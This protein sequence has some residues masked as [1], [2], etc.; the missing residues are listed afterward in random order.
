MQQ[1]IASRRIHHRLPIFL[2]EMPDTSIVYSPG[3]VAVVPTSSV[4]DLENALAGRGPVPPQWLARLADGFIELGRKA[5]DAWEEL[6]TAEMQPACLTVYLSNA[7]NLGCSYCF[8]AERDG[9]R[10]QPKSSPSLPILGSSPASP[11]LDDQKLIPA[12]RF[13]AESCRRQG[14]PFQLVVHGGGEATLHWDL[15]QRVVQLTK[16]VAGEQG[17]A[18]TSY[19]ASHGAI[20]PQKVCWLA[21]HF[22]RIGISCDGPPDIHDAQRS[23]LSGGGTYAN[24]AETI[25]ILG[26]SGV[27]LTLRA[28]ITRRSLRRQTEIVA[29]FANELGA[30]DI[31]FE[32]MYHG[33]ESDALEPDDAVEFANHFLAAQSVAEALGGRLKLSGVRLDEIHGPYCNVLRDVIQITPDHTASACFLVTDGRAP[34]GAEMVIGAVNPRTGDFEL[35]VDRIRRMRLQATEIP[36]RCHQC[37]NIYHCARDCP[38]VCP[39][40]D[41]AGP[42]IDQPGFRCLVQKELGHRWIID[43][44]LRHDDAETNDA[45]SETIVQSKAIGEALRDVPAYV[46]AE[47]IVRQWRLASSFGRFED[48]AMPAPPWS[49]AGFQDDGDAAWERLSRQLNRPQPDAAMSCYV[50]L[51]YC[52]RKCGF[53]DCYALLLLPGDDHKQQQ[54]VH[55]LIDEVRL[56]GQFEGLRRR[57][58]TT[59]HFGGGTPSYLPFYLIERFLDAF[60]TTFRDLPQTEWALESTTSQLDRERLEKLRGWGFSRLHVGLQ[61]LE[62]KTRTLIGRRESAAAALRK[63]ELA[64]EQGF[65]VSVDLVYGLP[66]QTLRQFVN[67]LEQVIELGVAGCSLYQL[68]VSHRNQTFVAANVSRARSTFDDY[69]YFQIGEA[70]LMARDYAK[71]HFAHFSRASDKNL[72]YTHV[73]RGEDLLAL[74]TTADGSFGSYCYRHPPIGDYVASAKGGRSPLEGGL[75][76]SVLAVKMRPI[77]ASLMAGVID[78]DQF[79]RFAA[80]ELRDRWLRFGML[81]STA[82]GVKYVLTANGSWFLSRLLT[83]LQEFL[84]KRG[85]AF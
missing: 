58:L 12:A 75:A 54:Y 27:D 31:R 70:I 85:D 35:D 62:D 9:S 60:R 8:A 30:R 23:K 78:A 49:R 38:D 15:L 42:A 46:N 53:C 3:N 76:E 29:F 83:E 36:A 72:Y 81:E 50:H 5:A 17:I 11:L 40:N 63:I 52:D 73:V 41:A 33:H 57:P 39:V 6:R 77:S 20:D 48:R 34:G 69:R 1:R 44:A 51:P 47:S 2:L 74:G 67:D 18:W 25:R 61:S 66:D 16:D 45:P 37:V 80:N 56:W 64:L 43:A 55:A 24:V 14:K 28:T 4:A 68:N 22:D 13:V 19:L 59:V 21:E 79:D 82:T 10:I 7:C 84:A 26:E 71:T 65:V 32:P